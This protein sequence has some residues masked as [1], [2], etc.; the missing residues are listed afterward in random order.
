MKYAA[1]GLQKNEQ[2]HYDPGRAP[3]EGADGH[4]PQPIRVE[5]VVPC[6]GRTEHFWDKK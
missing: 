3:L 1:Q 4:R 5:E 6:N 2:P